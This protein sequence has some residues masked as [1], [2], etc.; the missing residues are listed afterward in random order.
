[1]ESPLTLLVI[2]RSVRVIEHRIN[3]RINEFI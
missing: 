1:M 3:Y 2:F